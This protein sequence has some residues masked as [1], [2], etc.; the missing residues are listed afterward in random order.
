MLGK[1]LYLFK[2]IFFLKKN[3]LLFYYFMDLSYFSNFK[4]VFLIKYKIKFKIKKI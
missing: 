1:I 3:I 4:I 2:N